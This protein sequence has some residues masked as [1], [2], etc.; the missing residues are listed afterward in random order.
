MSLQGALE[1]ERGFTLVEVIITIIIMGIVFSI[2]SS[3][4][5]GAIESRKVDAA[6]NQVTADLRLAHSRATNRLENW[7]VIFAGDS[8]YTIGPTG[9]PID[10]DLDDDPDSN[11]VIIGPAATITFKPDGSATLPG[12]SPV[13]LTVS[14]A[15]GDPSHD[16]QINA[17]TSEI[18]VVP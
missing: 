18:K 8:T 11:P 3:I 7:Q 6:T 16:I 12:A 17:A 5:F 14:S 10:E 13:I 4:W 15:D 9:A 1:D 2:A